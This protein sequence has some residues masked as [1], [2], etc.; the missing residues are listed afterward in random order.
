MDAI[1]QPQEPIAGP[2]RQVQLVQWLRW[3]LKATVWHGL[4][5]LLDRLGFTPATVQVLCID[6]VAERLLVLRTGE[7][8]SG[9]CPVQGL[10]Q[11]ALSFGLTPLRA[12]VRE[13]ARRELLE[14]AVLEAPPLADFLVAERYREG[15][16]EQFDCTVLVVYRSMHELP[17][18]A[19]SGEG[20]PCWL[21]LG[22]AVAAF[23]NKTLRDMLADWRDEPATMGGGSGIGP[24]QGATPRARRVLAGPPTEVRAVRVSMPPAAAGLGN[25]QSATLKRAW[26]MPRQVLSA[27]R[28][29]G[30]RTADAVYQAD[31]AYA[32]ELWSGMSTAAR[33]C[34]RPDPRL[35]RDCRFLDTRSLPAL[36]AGWRLARL[37]RL[38]APGSN[39]E[40]LSTPGWATPEAALGLQGRSRCEISLDLIYDSEEDRVGCF[41][42][43]G[44]FGGVMSD[45]LL[46]ALMSGRYLPIPVFHTHPS[47]R[48]AIG[49]KQPSA[50]DFW[51]MGSLC[52]RLDGAPVG[53]AVFFPDGTWTEYG[54]TGHGRCF[55]RRAGDALLPPSGELV[56][57]FVDITLPERP[58]PSGGRPPS[59]G[60]GIAAMA[61]RQPQDT[62]AG[63]H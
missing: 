42:T 11:G 55:F 44:A 6:P 47:Y 16:Y 5:A 18:R 13:D 9:Y 17:L 21:P 24:E 54:I 39:G 23:A 52:Y 25:V 51:V 60:P 46:Y 27:A 63:A 48:T 7:Y 19:E 28:Q 57:S 49:Y 37:D 15:P 38:T 10:R 56:T 43:R 29:L 61:A 30:A 62:A 22:A 2:S 20:E 50:A 53:D 34:Y 14:E 32:A 33:D 3:L 36:L 40:A 12:D 26:P 41:L 58:R 45:V 8:A 31:P 35:W 59:H 1:Q 4:T